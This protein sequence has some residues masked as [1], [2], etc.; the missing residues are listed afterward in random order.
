MEAGTGDHR[1]NGDAERGVRELKRQ[2]RVNKSAIEAKLGTDIGDKDPILAWVPRIAAFLISRYRVD[3][4]GKTP[5]ERLT[6]K[7]WWRPPLEFAESLHYSPVDSRAARSDLQDRAVDGCYVGQD[8]GNS[9]YPLMTKDGIARGASVLRKAPSERWN[10]AG[11]KECKGLPW[12]WTPPEKHSLY[13]CQCR[14][15]CRTLR[16]RLLLRRLMLASRVREA[17]A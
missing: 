7:K 1:A 12:D 4:D 11:L 17:C 8:P 13:L 2:I 9:D 16:H 5:Y 6:G 15:R 3:E 10:T 14:S